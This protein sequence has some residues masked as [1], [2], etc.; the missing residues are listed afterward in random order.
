MGFSGKVLAKGN[1][2]TSLGAGGSGFGGL[3]AIA[4]EDPWHDT[5]SVWS[6]TKPGTV[7]D[8]FDAGARVPDQ[9]QLQDPQNSTDPGQYHVAVVP[10]CAPDGFEIE[11]K[12]V[13]CQILPAVEGSEEPYVAAKPERPGAVRFVVDGAQLPAVT[14]TFDLTINDATG[15]AVNDVVHV[16]GAGECTITAVVGDTLSLTYNGV[17]R[18][19][20]TIAA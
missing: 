1:A 20:V 3:G 18:A 17:P 4:C 14:G 5:Y 6:Q 13:V 15:Y 9:F 11:T 19:I 2:I 10:V 8:I 16:E 12:N 7:Q